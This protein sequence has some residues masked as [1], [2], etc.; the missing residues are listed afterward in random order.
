MMQ[1][2]LLHKL[3]TIAIDNGATLLRLETGVKQPEAL[4]LYR[5]AGF[6][7]T[8]F[9]PI[10][11]RSPQRVH[12]EADQRRPQTAETVSTWVHVCTSARATGSSSRW[13]ADWRN[14]H[15]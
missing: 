2:R 3:E 1:I 10:Q 9:R 6:V 12:G 11:P 5:S 7:E 4:L 14:I 8:S 13:Y 15:H